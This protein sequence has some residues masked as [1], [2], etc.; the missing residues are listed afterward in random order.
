[1]PT[2]NSLEQRALRSPI[3]RGREWEGGVRSFPQAI[4]VPIEGMSRKT[5]NIEINIPE[6]QLQN[7]GVQKSPFGSPSSGRTKNIDPEDQVIDPRLR[8]YQSTSFEPASR[9][10]SKTNLADYQPAD[11]ST[12]CQI[13]NL[14]CELRNSNHA[15]VKRNE[16]ISVLEEQLQAA[17]AKTAPITQAL[18]ECKEKIFE[19]QPQPELADLEIGDYYERLNEMIKDWVDNDFDEMTDFLGNIEIDSLEPSPGR[20]L[21]HIFTREE[22]EITRQSRTAHMFGLEYL[23][24]AFLAIRVFWPENLAPSLPSEY[25]DFLQDLKAGVEKQYIVEGRKG[26]AYSPRFIYLAKKL[27]RD[28]GSQRVES[29]NIQGHLA[30]PRVRRAPRS[31]HR[32]NGARTRNH[33]SESATCGRQT[34]I[35]AR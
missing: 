6:S 11:L 31:I 28:K 8:R 17:R 21:E 20:I 18:Q 30:S 24:H 33:F 10:A 16:Q 25:E 27:D 14:R 4:E 32:W 2:L 15:I 29:G 26:L 12:D 35:Q 5:A 22:I 13:Q 1:M 23:I 19:L 3:P 7:Q 9:H 34:W